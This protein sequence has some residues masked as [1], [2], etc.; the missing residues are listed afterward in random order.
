MKGSWGIGLA[1]RHVDL[2]KVPLGNDVDTWILRSDNCI[3]HNAIR[4][5]VVEQKFEEGDV[6]VRSN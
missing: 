5:F 2:N 6:I 3:Y 1:T 4:R